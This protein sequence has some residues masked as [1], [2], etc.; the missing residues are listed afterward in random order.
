MKDEEDGLRTTAREG[1]FPG[2]LMLMFKHSK[3]L[4]KD[5]TS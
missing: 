1:I 5:R 2:S 4:F 3:D